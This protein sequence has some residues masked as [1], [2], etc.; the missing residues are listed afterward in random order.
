MACPGGCAGGG[1]Q[2]IHEGAELAG[3][4]GERLWQLD[5][6]S[7]N[8]LFPREP[9]YPGP[10]PGVPGQT[11]GSAVP[12]PAPHGPRRLGYA[13]GLRT[14]RVSTAPG[15]QMQKDRP[16]RVQNARGGRFSAEPFGG[17]G[18]AAS[19]GRSTPRQAACPAAGDTR[20]KGSKELILS[21]GRLQGAGAVFGARPLK[22]DE[23]RKAPPAD[24]FAD[25]RV[26]AKN[27]EYGRVVFTGDDHWLG[28]YPAARL[29]CG[30]RK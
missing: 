20:P 15:P 3:E 19:E 22:Y 24:L 21:E 6:A 14:R 29:I 8:P 4:R 5:A 28:V 18:D 10:V 16:P 1:G 23:I 7:P 17:R 30:L 25:D 27:A 9:G 12:P 11:P 26:A 13:D 2:P